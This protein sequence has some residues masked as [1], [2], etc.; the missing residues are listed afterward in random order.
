[1]DF[2]QLWMLKRALVIVAAYSCR[3]VFFDFGILIVE[4][5]FIM[6]FSSYYG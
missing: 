5:C 3:A 4:K 1:M 6:I 2:W